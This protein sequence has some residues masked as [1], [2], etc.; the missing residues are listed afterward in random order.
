MKSIQGM[1]DEHLACQE[2]REKNGWYVT[3]L[4][5]CA[6]GVYL[7]RS[8]ARPDEA[9]DDRTLRV[10]EVGRVFEDHVLNVIKSHYSVKSQE[11]VSWPEFDLSGRYD[12]FIEDK[13][14]QA[15]LVE[16]KTMHSQGFHWRRKMGFQPLPHHKEQVMMYM[17]KLREDQP[18]LEASLC[19]ISKDD[20]CMMEI[21]ILWDE[22]LYFEGLEKAAILK[23]AWDSKITDN[24]PLPD[25]IIFDSSKK[26]WVLNWVADYCSFH[27]QCASNPNW[28]QEAQEE[29]K[30]RNT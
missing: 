1:W 24:L 13:E 11:R 20:L 30:K 7:E 6:R 19:Y 15:R 12:A 25:P 18:N 5:R 29:I 8:G 10:F 16:F 23:E 28:K 22:N 27:S 21:P 26:K 14:G 2:K 9:M 17:G 4:N 3:D